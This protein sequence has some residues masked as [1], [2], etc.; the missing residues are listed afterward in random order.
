MTKVRFLSVVFLIAVTVQSILC[1][2]L[3]ENICD[4]QLKSFKSAFSRSELWAL[5]RKN[6]NI[7]ISVMKLTYF[8]Q[9]LTRGEK[10]SLDCLI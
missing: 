7:C 5:Q 2:D 10:F 1:L 9:Y 3:E 6:L 8:P 4:D